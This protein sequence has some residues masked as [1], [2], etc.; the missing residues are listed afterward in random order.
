ML[1]CV[2]CSVA[3]R[4]RPIGPIFFLLSPTLTDLQSG[5]WAHNFGLSVDC[6]MCSLTIPQQHLPAAVVLDLCSLGVQ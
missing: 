6:V 5:G 1:V 3:H 4:C 2:I